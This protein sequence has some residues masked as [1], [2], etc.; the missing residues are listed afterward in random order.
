MGFKSFGGAGIRN[1]TR[2]QSD[3]F[4]QIANI[5]NTFTLGNSG[6]TNAN[7]VNYIAYLWTEIPG[8][9]KF[10]SYS[11]NG[12][13]DGTF[14]WCGFNPALVIIKRITNVGSWVLMD[15]ARN[16][17]N[18]AIRRVEPD[19]S[20]AEQTNISLDFLSNGFK[21]RSNTTFTNGSG[22]TYVFMAF[23]EHPFKYS[24]AR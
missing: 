16:E 5:Q 8:F 9:S 21:A 10:G 2:L 22:D 23:A 4:M 3:A 7:G 15:S 18:E 24:N 17:T 20:D 12:S 6:G 14:V 19:T 13:V 1:A 11:G